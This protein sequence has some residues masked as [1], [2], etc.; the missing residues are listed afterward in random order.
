MA[1]RNF[2]FGLVASALAVFAPATGATADTAAL[3]GQAEETFDAQISPDGKHVALGCSPNGARAV[4]IYPLAGDG[5][6]TL[7][8]IADDQRLSDYY[9]A[10]DK[11]LIANINYYERRNTST[12]FREYRIDRAI[13]YNIQNNR[14]AMLMREASAFD[15]LVDVNSVC[16]AKPDKVFMELTTRADDGATTGR[17]VGRRDAGVRTVLYS[18]DLDKGSMKLSETGNASVT[19]HILNRSCKPIARVLFND[20]EQSFAIQMIEG[21]RTL[22]EASDVVVAPAT[23]YGFNDDE[24]A[25]I[26][27][28]DD[29]ARDG[30]YELAV[31]DGALTPVTL[32]ETAVGDAGLIRDRYRDTVAGYFWTDD[33]DEQIFVDPELKDVHEGLK[34]ALS[35][36]SVQLRSWSR[37]RSLF[38]LIVEAPGDPAAFMLYDKAQGSVSP[39]GAAA[40]QLEGRAIGAVSAVSYTARDGTRIPAYLTLP[41]GKTPADGPFPLVLMP[42]G[43]PEARDTAAYDWWAQ[44]YA[45]EGYLV[46][47]PNFRGSAGYGPQFR[48]AGFGEFGGKMVEDVIDGAAFLE[49][50]GLAKPG[51][52]CI[53]GAS[54]GGYSALMAPLLDSDRIKCSVAVNPVSDIFS[55][56]GRFQRE[57]SAYNYWARYAGGT[58]YQS[59]DSKRAITP[60]ERLSE[61]Q[62][63]ILIIH[64]REDTTVDVDQSQRFQRDWGDRAGL[65][66]IELDGEDHYLTGTASR[67][68][69][70]SESLAFMATNHPAR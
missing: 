64:G 29:G 47:Q 42:H 22:Y 50:E 7:F 17:R 8:Q 65:T 18:V 21:R 66:Y 38:S 31:S 32:G 35:G 19:T 25:L 33:L 1:V 34:G 14:T 10:S 70:L 27:Y 54:Y 53:A 23:V 44:A 62:S 2:G 20:I 40:P 16:D 11:H 45:A 46:L 36:K 30:L 6:P 69:V 37:D 63:P 41:A 55:H 12:G 28:L 13:A 52:V 15:S 9:W 48:D 39:L 56:M 4:C 3:F 58:A 43:G 26:I 59:P 24:T 51:G 5:K 49:T 67:Q 57:T 61:Y 68:R 60:A